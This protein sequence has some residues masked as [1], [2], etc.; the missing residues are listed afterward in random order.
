MHR[1]GNARTFL[2]VQPDRKSP[3]LPD[4]DEMTGDRGGRGAAVE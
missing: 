1:I 2:T 4:V 3:P